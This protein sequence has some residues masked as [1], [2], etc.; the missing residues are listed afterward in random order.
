MGDKERTITRSFKL[1]SAYYE[2]GISGEDIGNLARNTKIDWKKPQIESDINLM[3]EALLKSDFFKYWRSWRKSLRELTQE[4][5]AINYTVLTLIDWENKGRPSTPSSTSFKQFALNAKILLDKSIYEY[6]KNQWKG[7]SDS[8]IKRNIEGARKNSDV[9]IPINKEKWEELISEM[10]DQGTINGIKYSAS[11][12]VDST[13]KLLL[14]YF[15]V[16]NSRSGPDWTI[17]KLFEFDHIIP[18]SEIMSSN[19]EFA[20]KNIS[21]LFNIQTLPKGD[22]IIKGDKPLT[23]ITDNWRIEQIEKYSHIPHNKF[24][25]FSSFDDMEALRT[26]RGSII[27]ETFS[28]KRSEVLRE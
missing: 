4:A 1:L 9:W 14:I 17:Y 6:I 21:N 26:Y 18:R 8:K 19:N 10:I 23:N 11:E 16:L 7:S 13:V 28:D 22:N 12:K 20:K 24:S 27:K 3:S 5:I 2:G 15:N 25:D